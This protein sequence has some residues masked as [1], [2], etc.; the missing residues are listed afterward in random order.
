MATENL[1]DEEKCLP[2]YHYFNSYF[3]V[4]KTCTQLPYTFSIQPFTGTDYMQDFLLLQESVLQAA[5]QH[6]IRVAVP[7][8]IFFLICLG[9]LMWLGIRRNP[10]GYPFQPFKELQ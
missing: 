3:V 6:A 1:N 7:I 5:Q 9:I 2:F 8:G 4:A 10:S